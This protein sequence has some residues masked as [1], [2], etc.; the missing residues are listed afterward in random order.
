MSTTFT[1]MPI[2]ARDTK[3]LARLW[4]RC[5]PQMS[6]NIGFLVSEAEPFEKDSG[7]WLACPSAQQSWLDPGWPSRYVL[8]AAPMPQKYLAFALDCNHGRVVSKRSGHS[9]RGI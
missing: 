2:G 1:S 6:K 8:R 5:G 3:M 7:F 4:L 9:A